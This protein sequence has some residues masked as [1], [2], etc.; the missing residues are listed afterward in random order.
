VYFARPDSIIDGVSVYEARLGM[1]SML[2]KK[3]LTQFP[4]HNI[5]VVIPIPD[6]SRTSALQCAYSMGIPYREGYIK[7]RYIASKCTLFVL[8]TFGTTA[9]LT[10]S[11]LSNLGTFI[12]PGQ[13]LRQK[14]IRLKLNTIRSE[15]KDKTVLLVDDSIVRGIP[16]L[17]TVYVNIII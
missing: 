7:N 2:A 16:F 11:L 4:T 5:D 14:K 12:M 6:T 1:G 3:I 13:A 10:S 9:I 15:F 17:T 8:C